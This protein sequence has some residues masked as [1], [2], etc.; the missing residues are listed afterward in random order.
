MIANKI[1]VSWNLCGIWLLLSSVIFLVACGETAETQPTA[2]PSTPTT[3]PTSTSTAV[4][5]AT[6]TV[7]PTETPTVVP[8]ET[9]TLAPTDTPRPTA[10]VSFTW[11]PDGV[12]PSDADDVS[13]I[14]ID[15][16]REEEG[17]VSGYG[18]EQGIT[19]QY[20]PALITVEE[21]QEIL[22]RIGHPVT[23]SQ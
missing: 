10:Q 20:D 15:L 6:P 7:A 18:N 2:I 1:K 17:V 3:E 12:R 11:H 13:A 21:I 22:R 9:P 4:P 16:T 19:L 23:I 14:V 5:T 8:T